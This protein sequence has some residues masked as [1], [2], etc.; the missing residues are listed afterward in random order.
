MWNS[1]I[2][3]FFPFAGLLLFFF[4]LHK[5]NIQFLC[6]LAFFPFPILPSL[7][8]PIP[9]SSFLPL[10]PA[11]L[12]FF[13]LLSV[14][15]PY[16]SRVWVLSFLP[17][18]IP[19]IYFFFHDSILLFFFHFIMLFSPFQSHNTIYLPPSIY[20]S[21]F[22]ILIFMSIHSYCFNFYLHRNIWISTCCWP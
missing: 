11:P 2:V 7:P 14:T 9:F 1:N 3:I 6:L 10:F 12:F 16:P 15:P 18:S 8:P 21:V 5:H 20:F 4:W 17:L 22:D 19:P 13:P